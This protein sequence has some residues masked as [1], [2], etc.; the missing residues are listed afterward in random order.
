MVKSQ[1][2]VGQTTDKNGMTPKEYQ[3]ERYIEISSHAV[4]K[5]KVMGPKIGH[6]PLGKNLM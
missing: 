5:E 1:E 4:E 3:K 2:K 6:P